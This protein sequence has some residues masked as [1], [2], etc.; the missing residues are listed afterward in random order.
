[1][2]PVDVSWLEMIS[3]ERNGEGGGGG[4]DLLGKEEDDW[5]NVLVNMLMADVWQ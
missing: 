2:V 1:M 4:G 5:S 3:W